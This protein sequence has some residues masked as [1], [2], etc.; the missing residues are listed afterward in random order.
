MKLTI[1]RDYAAEN[2][3]SA[4]PRQKKNSVVVK[5][6]GCWPLE[7]CRRNDH[8]YLAETLNC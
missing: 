7:S 2:L 8:V 5:L 3:M 4:G 1:L 6:T